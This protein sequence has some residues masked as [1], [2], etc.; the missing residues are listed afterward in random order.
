MVYSSETRAFEFLDGHVG[1]NMGRFRSPGG[2]WISGEKCL[3]YVLYE[4]GFDPRELLPDAAT[5]YKRQ[6]L[7]A[8]LK[9]A[10]PASKQRST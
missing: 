2:V 5:I 1:W 9:A 6:E 4:L 10:A 7:K 8:E 3:Q